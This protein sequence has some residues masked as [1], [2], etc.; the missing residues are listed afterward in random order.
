M[1]KFGIKCHN[2]PR[3]LFSVSIF[4]DQNFSKGK[5]TFLL[6]RYD[7]HCIRF[8]RFTLPPVHPRNPISENASK[9]VEILEPNRFLPFGLVRSF[10][11]YFSRLEG[12]NEPDYKSY[13]VLCACPPFC[14][15]LN[16]PLP[17][18]TKWCLQPCGIKK[19][20]SSVKKA[21]LKTRF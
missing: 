7:F 9:L 8:S 20:N 4:F 21:M 3:G 13:G 12:G 1:P 2:P 6:C 14:H 10:S 16:I 15:A 19:T 5:I 17:H 11:I 18:G